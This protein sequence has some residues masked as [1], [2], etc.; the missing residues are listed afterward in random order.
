MRLSTSMVRPDIAILIGSLPLVPSTA[1]VSVLALA[2]MA[3]RPRSNV[4]VIS[5][6][7]KS[8]ELPSCVTFTGAMRAVDAVLPPKLTM[9]SV[10]RGETS[11]VSSNTGLTLSVLAISVWT[12]A[13]LGAMAPRAS[14]LLGNGPCS[15]WASNSNMPSGMSLRL[16]SLLTNDTP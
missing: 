8:T 6:P 2:V 14:A 3:A 1:R 7:L 13:S 5:M 16:L 12:K 15:I 9:A 10:T 4:P 11:L